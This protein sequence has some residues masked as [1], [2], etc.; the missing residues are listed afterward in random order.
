MDQ[1]T[2]SLASLL[3]TSGE[4]LETK[5]QIEQLRE[6]YGETWLQSHGGSLVQVRKIMSVDQ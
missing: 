3:V 1:S 2:A 6:Q 5:R 4:H